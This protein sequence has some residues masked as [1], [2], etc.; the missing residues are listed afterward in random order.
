M[1]EFCFKCFIE[2]NEITC[3]ENQYIISKDLD[4]CEGCGT[5]AHVI[6]AKRRNF[7]V[8]KCIVL[9]LVILLLF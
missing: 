4:L 1:A 2:F 9:T 6:V 8:L 3:A 7:C 5:L